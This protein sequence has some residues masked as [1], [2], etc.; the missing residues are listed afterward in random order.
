[1]SS[2]HLHI[3]PNLVMVFAQFVDLMLVC[4]HQRW[5]VSV[6]GRT[7]STY[8][9]LLSANHTMDHEKNVPLCMAR[10]NMMHYSYRGTYESQCPSFG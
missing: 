10:I 7:S 4:L 1:M 5:M 6:K 2:F 8:F 3:L 9:C